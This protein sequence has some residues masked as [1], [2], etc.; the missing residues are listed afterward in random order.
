MRVYVADILGGKA[1]ALEGEAHAPRRAL[2]SGGRGGH[3]VGV[4]VH[5][6]AD[7]LG[8]NPR[9]PLLRALHLFEDEHAGAFAYY[10]A[11]SLLVKGPTC[12]RRRAVARG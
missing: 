6:V 4:G 3:V 11:V 8:V 10:K 12:R 5:A 7:Y 2:P 1:R 9:A